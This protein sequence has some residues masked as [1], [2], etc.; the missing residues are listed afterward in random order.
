MALNLCIA[1]TDVLSRRC[2][3]DTRHYLVVL[4]MITI[5]FVKLMPEHQFT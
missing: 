4:T 1:R 5:C 2:A 3:W